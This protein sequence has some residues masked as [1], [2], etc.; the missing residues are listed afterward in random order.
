MTAT[1]TLSCGDRCRFS[2]DFL[3]NT[4]QVA[5][6]DAPTSQ[7]P[8]ARGTVLNVKHLNGVSDIVQIIWDDSSITRALASNLERCS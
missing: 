6:P 2:S 8:W 4:G 1:T 3:R 7:G 5:G